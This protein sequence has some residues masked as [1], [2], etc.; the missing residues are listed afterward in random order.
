V[1]R[2]G[3]AQQEQTR[4]Q[5]GADAEPSGNNGLPQVFLPQPDFTTGSADFQ[6]IVSQ[7]MG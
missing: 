1:W 5:H 4:A 7:A 2:A 3:I 6:S